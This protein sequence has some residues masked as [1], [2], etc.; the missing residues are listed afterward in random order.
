[1]SSRTVRYTR[2][3]MPT[4][5]RPAEPRPYLPQSVYTNRL[6]TIRQCMLEKGLDALIVYGDR[7]HFA[8]MKYVTNYDPRFEEALLIIYS[9]GTPILYIGNE[10]M[11]YSNVAIL[12]VERRLYQSLSLLDQPREQ[13][14]P[15]YDMLKRD[16]LGECSQVGV[17]GWKYFNAREFPEAE[18]LLEIPEHLA[19]S[20][21]KAVGGNVTNATAMFMNPQDG[22]RNINEP[23][24]L[25]DFEWVA[26]QN[27]QNV[28]E[29]LRGIAPGRSEHEIF[30]R[31]PYMGIPL[32]CSPVCATG[33]HLRRTVLPSATSMVVQSGDPFFLSYS[34]QGA[35]T[36]R[37]G[38]VAQGPEEV[39]PE[40][41]D[42]L[43]KTAFPYFEALAA[44]YETLQVGATGDALHH[45]VNDRLRPLGMTLGLNAGHLIAD[46]EWTSSPVWD[47]SSLTVRSGMYWQADFFPAVEG[48]Q[49]GAFA[50]DGVAV[51]DAALRAELASRY[52]AM[53]ARIQER[54]RF[55]VDTLGIRLGDDV[56]PFS[57]FC[58]AIIPFMLSPDKTIV[59]AE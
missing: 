54:R 10:G 18:D 21:R 36:C 22:L 25:A 13:V 16:G 35:N 46:D 52:P 48:G 5:G 41:R 23:E 53:W 43:D 44:W 31:I 57:N 51:A 17:A 29:G 45:A 58:A 32:C 33:D 2:V 59:Y 9:T 11:A 30:A 4:I 47:G 1:M 14:E 6:H 42:Y 3:A 28:L 50:E 8:T 49:I 19:Y 26:T 20:L 34:Y 15:L 7:E 56:L 27:S 12:P 40:V 55:M 37:F 24:Q 38:W 39:A